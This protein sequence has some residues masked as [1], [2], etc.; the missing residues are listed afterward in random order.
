MLVGRNREEKVE[1]EHLHD[2]FSGSDFPTNPLHSNQNT[3]NS[4]CGYFH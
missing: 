3:S 4:L 2:L 1:T